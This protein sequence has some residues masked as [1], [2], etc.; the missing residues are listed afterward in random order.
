MSSYFSSCTSHSLAH[1]LCASVATL[2]FRPSKSQME[3]SKRVLS[4]DLGLV[5]VRNVEGP[6]ANLP[7]LFSWTE[8]RI[9]VFS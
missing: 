6:W 1:E 8:N 4:L 2:G 9:S 5:P 7:Q 3:I